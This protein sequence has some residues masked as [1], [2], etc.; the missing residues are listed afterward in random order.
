MQ[1]RAAADRELEPS[2]PRRA[3]RWVVAG[4]AALA[5]AA[6]GAAV[7]S[8]RSGDREPSPTPTSVEPH[9]DP[10][11]LFDPRELRHVQN[12]T[13]IEADVRT[14]DQTLLSTLE[15]RRLCRRVDLARSTAEQASPAARAAAVHAILD[16][17]LEHSAS[18][19]VEDPSVVDLVRRLADELAAGNV[20]STKAWVGSSCVGD[21]AL[22]GGYVDAEFP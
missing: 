7:V 12:L 15:F 1:A 10:F 3:R 5:V 2:R 9:N 22:T 6:A 4:V 20:T 19:E 17:E 14:P 16:P 11:A 21:D 8:H 13:G 18:S